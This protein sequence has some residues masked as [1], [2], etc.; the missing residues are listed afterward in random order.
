[1]TLDD[2]IRQYNIREKRNRKVVD[3]FRE[4][5]AQYPEIPASSLF[6]ALADRYTKMNAA[7]GLTANWE[8]FPQSAT[9]IRDLLVRVGA[10][11]RQDKEA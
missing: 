8:R 11:K 5:C 4:L 3:D 2:K 10:Y 1:M 7:Q 6:D 9:G